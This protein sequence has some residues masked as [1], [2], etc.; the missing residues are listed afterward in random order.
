MTLQVIGIESEDL[1]VAATKQDAIVSSDSF[2]EPT[3]PDSISVWASTEREA[4]VTPSGLGYSLNIDPSL[5]IE[6]HSDLAYSVRS[7][8][9]VKQTDLLNALSTGSRLMRVMR[10]DLKI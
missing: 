5:H 7:R 2:H 3:H 10:S 6:L 1:H 9:T 8:R 4:S